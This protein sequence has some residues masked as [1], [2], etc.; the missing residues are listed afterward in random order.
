MKSTPR[1]ALE[2][3]LSILPIDLC[4]EE[5]QRYE[6]VKLLIKENDYIQSNMIGRN[7]AHKM[8]GP[9]EKLRSVTKQILQ[10]LS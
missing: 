7:K 1:D 10:F 6:A 8:S 2:S 3:K 4:L 9:F 5:M